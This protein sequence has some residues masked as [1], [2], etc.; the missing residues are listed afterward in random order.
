MNTFQGY[1]VSQLAGLVNEISK[2]LRSRIPRVSFSEDVSEDVKAKKMYRI[3]DSVSVDLQSVATRLESAEY[4][5]DP[6]DM[7]G[8]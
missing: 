5:S 4:D 1:S 3:F 6:Y 7:I 2:E 8:A